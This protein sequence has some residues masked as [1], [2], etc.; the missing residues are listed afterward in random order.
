MAKKETPKSVGIHNTGK[1][2]TFVNITTEGFDVGVHDEGTGSQSVDLR[3]ILRGDA[4]ARWYE[5]P[6]GIVAL[7]VVAGIIVGGAVYFFGWTK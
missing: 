1:D 6:L 7:M 2:N 5:R 4:D 3:N